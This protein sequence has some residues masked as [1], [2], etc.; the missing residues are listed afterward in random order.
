MRWL[1]SVSI[2]HTHDEIVLRNRLAQADFIQ[3]QICEVAQQI[4]RGAPPLCGGGPGITGLSGHRTV[5]GHAAAVRTGRPPPLPMSK[6][7]DGVCGTR[8]IAAVFG[9]YGTIT[10][11]G[12][13]HARKALV[14][15]AWKY[16]RVPRLSLALQ[17]RQQY[18]SARTIAISNR[19]QKRLYK[20]YH[21]LK[22]R[23]SPKVA[24]VAVARELCERGKHCS[25]R[26]QRCEQGNN[27]GEG[28]PVHGWRTHVIR[29]SVAL[30]VSPSN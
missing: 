6:D 26:P 28:S 5:Y 10:K 3:V 1:N 15:A 22:H 25:R 17:K 20:R 8:A 13:V 23:K 24:A 7:A 21:A 4:L 18:C 16:T 11:T 14:S 2:A 9:R 19:A 29:L 12:H 27:H 30:R